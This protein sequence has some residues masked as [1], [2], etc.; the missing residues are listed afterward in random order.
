MGNSFLNDVAPEPW[1]CV[2]MPGRDVLV[3]V[4]VPLG[5]GFDSRVAFSVS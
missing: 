5:H 1:T 4:L 2:D 3:F